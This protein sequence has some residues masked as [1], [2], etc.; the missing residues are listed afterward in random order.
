MKR[1][2]QV[3]LDLLIPLL[4]AGLFAG[5]NLMDLY[6]GAEMRIYDLLLHVKPAVPEDNSLLF[7]DIDDT[8]IANVGVFPWSR[9]IM[10][11]GLILMRE[12][13]SRYAVFDIEYTEKS[14]LGVNGTYLNQRIPEVFQQE[15]ASIEQNVNDLFRALQTGAIPLG[16]AEDYIRDLTSLADSS[17]KLLLER[18]Q[19]IARDNDGY[20]GRA[21]RLNGSAYFTVNMLPYEEGTLSPELKRYVE[22]HIALKQVTADQQFPFTAR[23]IRPAILPVLQGAAGA[24]FPNVIVDPDGVRRRIDL[25]MEWDGRYYAQLAFAALLDW[26]GNP[27]VVVGPGRVQLKG[28]T[29]PG[30]SPRDISIPLA[31]D[32]RMLIN[33]PKKSYLDSF[34]HITYYEL[35][36]HRRLEQD[37]LY[38]LRLME[39]AGYLRYYQGDFGLLDPYRYAESIK[40]E[41]LSGGEVEMMDEYRQSRAV[42]F[43]EVGSF[44]QDGEERIGSQLGHILELEET[45]EQTRQNIRA[46]QADLPK[47]FG[48]TRDLYQSLMRLRASL[49]DSLGGAFCII[50]WTGTSTTDIGVNP[51]EEKYMNVGTHAALVNT[52]LSGRFLDSLP[53]WYSAI[54]G[55]VLAVLAT[56]AVRRLEPLPSILIGL[57]ILAALV[58]AGTL[59]FLLTGIYFPLLTPTLA[60]FFTLIVLILFKFLILGQE[61]SFLRNAFSHYLSADV[62]SELIEDPE[63]L[64]LGGQKKY[65]TAMFTDVRG[66]S[67]ISEKMD[68]T[69]LVKLLNAYLT[70]MSDIILEEK[71][72]IDKYEGDAIICFFGAPVG[73]H[74]HALRACR[75][76]VQ[77]KRAERLLNERF[78][79]Q[80]LSPSPLA[81]RIGI[82]TGDMVVGNMGT[83]KKM[84]YTIMGNSVNLASRLEGVNKQYGTWVL[85]SEATRGDAGD[86]FAF[87]RLDRVRVVGIN[88]PVRLYELIDEKAETSPE[89]LQA[90][91][92]FQRG[93]ERFE[94]KDWALAQKH[95]Q[96]VQRMVPDDGPTAIYLKRC[97]EFRR[98]P[99][100]PEWDGVFNLTLK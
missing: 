8:A 33:W 48:P 36:Q 87:R 67:T 42:F 65:I 25:I 19:E 98:T 21:A 58:G 74:D 14:P 3:P 35:V 44:L 38:N 56:L 26:L 99:P 32:R 6:R 20:L 76:A 72:T 29:P 93:L 46:I 11:D 94:E 90:V 27:A 30:G 78:R 23:D 15:F 63:K 39:D 62:I 88:E 31:E 64:V 91:E 86:R 28:A 41:V 13:G 66:F 1:K 95:F 97:R 59:F 7:V 100:R 37:L 73:F 34:R 49:K 45:T 4:V 81:T 70:E 12:L 43:R 10:A 53:W 5:L 89:M 69:D 54:L 92:I 60:V 77:M 55:A 61:K 24:G 51:F 52:I 75:S 47:V 2:R 50:G 18:V 96:E 16:E 83:D 71:G 85:V 68:P 22:E 79:A 40:E 57:S 17:R 9:D 80:S 82:N 84:D